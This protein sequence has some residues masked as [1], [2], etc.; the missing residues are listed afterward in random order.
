MLLLNYAHP[1]TEEQLAHLEALAGVRPA[2]RS[3]A[4]QADRS[5]SFAQQACALADAAGLT[6]E[7]WQ[8]TPLLINPP[9][10]AALALALLTE[11]HGRC[12][13]FVPV[14]NIRPVA[15]S[16]PPRFEIAEIIN[17]QAL[18][19]EARTRRGA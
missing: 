18:R 6:G 15:G 2:V 3:L 19:E 4:A 16:V 14:L 9:G 1:L 12:G 17:L 13:Y 7:A 8:T 10:L 5:Q 11:V